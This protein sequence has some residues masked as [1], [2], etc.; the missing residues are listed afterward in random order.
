MSNIL[1]IEHGAFGDIILATAGFAAIRRHHPDAHITCLTTKPYAELL[2]QSPFFDEIWIDT[3]PR[4]SDIKAIRVLRTLLNSKRWEWVY[5]LQTSTRTTAYQWL[6]ARP[7]PKISNISRWASHGYRE[8]G[9][10]VMHA[11]PNLAKQLEV[12]GINDV[13]LPEINWL[14]ADITALRPQ[15]NYALLVPGGAAHRPEKRWPAAQYTALAAALVEQKITPVLIGAEAESDALA[16]IATQVPQ[17]LNLCGKTSIAELASLART[18]TVAVG[19][20][21]GPMHVIAAAGTP[22]VVLFSHASNPAY[23]APMGKAVRVLRERNLADL[24]VER[25]LTVVCNA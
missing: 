21:T 5:D 9:R 11:S 17:A 18:A 15:E 19:N 16:E 22:S 13:R 24:S 3:K 4:F 10:V 14:S 23:S 12:A 1:V 2:R 25:V 8:P 6:L 7:W 20:D